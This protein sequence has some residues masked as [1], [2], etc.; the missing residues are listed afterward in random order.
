MNPEAVSVSEILASLFA[1]LGLFFIG[2]KLIGSNLKRLSGPRMR[3]LVEVA[4]RSRARSS[5]LGT[6]AGVMTQSSNA[7]TFI[8][9]SMVA[10]GL[11]DV[12]RAMP[13]VAWSSV[14]TSALV[15]LATVDIQIAVLYL[16]GVIGM[17]YF[18]DIEA[19]PRYRD[20]A[21]AALG[22]GLLFLGLQLIHEGA[23]PAG[24]LEGLRMYLDALSEFE[25]LLLLASVAVTIVLQSSSTVSV[26][27]VTM[28]GAGLL[29]LEQAL[30][31]ITGANA[32]SGLS[33][34]LM[35]AGQVGS[36][37]RL[38]L[39]QVETKLVASLMCL[40]LLF[41]ERYLGA[42]GVMALGHAAGLGTPAHGAAYF[43]AL[44]LTGA[45]LAMAFDG[46][47][48]ALAGRFSPE[49]HQETLAR[50]RYL[51]AQALE[52]STTALE[53]LELE[54]TRLLGHVGCYL[55]EAE[56]SA[57]L[58]AEEPAA[59][60][61]AAPELAEADAQVGAQVA[62]FMGALADRYHDAH[63]GQQLLRLQERL[64]SIQELGAAVRELDTWLL[65][66]DTIED[67]NREHCVNLKVQ[68]RESC[69][70]LLEMLYDTTASRSDEDL[71]ILDL[72]VHDRSEVMDGLRKGWMQ[73]AATT[74]QPM[75]E[76]LFAA[77]SLFE[78]SVWI[79]RR[80][81][82]TLRAAAA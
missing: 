68:V 50:P 61:A 34:L 42:P 39:V 14:G 6:L 3:R 75:L 53:L 13:V 29:D 5:V 25:I 30:V 67:P 1:G 62:R 23:Q 82:Q 54:Q 12:R 26:I 64:R 65:R 52:E 21:G 47:F 57:R 71:A 22:T 35:S 33:V 37:R 2:V 70:F 24:E 66:I 46:T 77:T 76:A 63:T 48:L 17:A 51:Y 36:T 10:A 79:V 16:L 73:Q 15:L 45:L 20:A 58:L 78:R 32:G 74:G 56:P 43:V 28:A 72:L 80:V 11:L 59:N 19:S 49:S 41:A 55:S 18:F 9:S 4:V 60:H 38:A 81:R 69:H 31:L 44:Q 8:L 7:V 27:A 40:L